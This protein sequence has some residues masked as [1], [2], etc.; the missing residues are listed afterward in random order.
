MI[1]KIWNVIVDLTW[2]ALFV[3]MFYVITKFVG[4]M[5]S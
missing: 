2:G 3:T 1:R 4:P 5:D